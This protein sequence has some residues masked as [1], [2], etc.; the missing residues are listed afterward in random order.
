MYQAQIETIRKK[1]KSY[2]FG[3]SSCTIDRLQNFPPKL[4]I[5]ADEIFVM[6]DSQLNRIARTVV[7]TFL[8]NGN[9]PIDR[10]NPNRN[11]KNPYENKVNNQGY[12]QRGNE[13]PYSDNVVQSNIFNNEH[14]IQDI[15]V[16][17]YLNKFCHDIITFKMCEKLI[18][19]WTS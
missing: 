10:N 4:L 12:G 7:P 18:D 2:Q 6:P 17:G 13:A 3:F 11:F 16:H 9:P 1:L 19:L 15:T 5:V 14:E 8:R